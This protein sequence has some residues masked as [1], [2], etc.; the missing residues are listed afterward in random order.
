[1]GSGA[2]RS[3]SPRTAAGA[4]ETVLLTL[5]W[6]S[7][8]IPLVWVASPR[9]RVRGLSAAAGPARGGH[10]LLRARALDLPPLA[11]R[12]RN[13]L[14]DH[15]RSSARTTR[16]SRRHLPEDPAP[17]VPLAPDLLARPGARGAQLDRG[18]VLCRGDGAPGRASPRTRRTDGGRAVRRRV[19][20]RTG[21]GRRCSSPGFSDR[22]FHP[23]DRRRLHRGFDRHHAA[24]AARL[25]RRPPEA[26][27][28]LEAGAPRSRRPDSDLPVRRHSD[29]HGDLRVV[30]HRHARRRARL[31]R[32]PHRGQRRLDHPEPRVVARRGRRSVTVYR[33]PGIRR[34]PTPCPS[35]P[36][37]TCR[38][39]PSW[40]RRGQPS[41]RHRRAGPRL[42][43][44]GLELEPPAS[45]FRDLGAGDPRPSRCGRTAEAKRSRSRS[46]STSA[47][48]SSPRSRGCVARPERAK[49]AADPFRRQ[50][51]HDRGD[52][53][54]AGRRGPLRPHRR[55]PHG[56]PRRDGA[57]HALRGAAPDRRRLEMWQPFRSLTIL[58]FEV[59][60]A[61][62]FPKCVRSTT[63][64]ASTPTCPCS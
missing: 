31:R 50:P 25:A 33:A 23:V 16:S 32:P 36:T 54:G 40:S 37:T 15:P 63:S 48:T 19:G 57:P 47:G 22:E 21:A 11:P 49:P 35:R 7:F 51:R 24:R 42:L 1:M 56:R 9:L 18:P 8:F 61:G 13:E 59:W 44:G 10:G 12:S 41:A 28:F 38:S 62:T 29:V 64:R 39:G 17:D 2:G 52:P 26:R 60:T 53:G 43:C 46:A 34:A 14:V 58:A 30:A 4:L 6:L 27:A 20:R 5:A 3:G 55:R 45:M